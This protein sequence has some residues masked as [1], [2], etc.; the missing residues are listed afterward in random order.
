MLVKPHGSS[1]LKPMLVRTIGPNLEKQIGM[2]PRELSDLL[3]LGMGAYTPLDGFM[4]YD[5]WRGV[6]EDMTLSTGVFWPIPITLSVNEEIA[7]LHFIFWKNTHNA[8]KPI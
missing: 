1:E 8:L 7:N 5:D 4:G 2:T 6:C 3:M